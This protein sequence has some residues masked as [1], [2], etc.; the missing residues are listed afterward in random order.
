MNAA[1]VG[2]A[3]RAVARHAWRSRCVRW[4][5]GLSVLYFAMDLLFSLEMGAR[6]LLSPEGSIHLDAVLLGAACI[7][8][9]VVGR[10]AIPAL[11]VF[12]LAGVGLESLLNARRP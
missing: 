8:T 7:G 1:A 2:K 3:A 12:G 5:I 6:G 11:L 10:F 9:R 4:G